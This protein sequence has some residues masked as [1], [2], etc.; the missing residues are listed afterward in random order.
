MALTYYALCVISTWSMVIIF[1]NWFLSLNIEKKLHKWIEL[2][3]D[4]RANYHCLYEQLL[5]SKNND[6]KSGTV[7]AQVRVYVI[8]ILG[9][10]IK[11]SHALFINDSKVVLVISS[12]NFIT[13]H[14]LLSHV[15]RSLIEAKI[16]SHCFCSTITH[17][18]CS[19]IFK[20]L[21]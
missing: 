11:S 16:S 1:S 20:W 14:L 8:Q 6:D 21:T 19:Q 18:S 13:I 5:H 2:K 10:R 17:P 4:N 15:N 7:S 9:K 3:F 12:R